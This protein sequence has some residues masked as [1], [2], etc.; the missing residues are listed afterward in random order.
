MDG[1]LF[2]L[3]W[4]IAWSLAGH[5]NKQDF[6]FRRKRNIAEN[7]NP[8]LFFCGH[9]TKIDFIFCIGYHCIPLGM[10]NYFLRFKIYSI[11]HVN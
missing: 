6:F 10:Y 7:R 3:L 4:K 1:K 8:N 11:C 9:P 5:R 2:R